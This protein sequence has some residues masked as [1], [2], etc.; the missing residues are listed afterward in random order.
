MASASSWSDPSSANVE[1][2]WEESEDVEHTEN[3]RF[4]HEVSEHTGM[5]E[6]TAF[7]I[8]MGQYEIRRGFYMHFAASMGGV[9][10]A[11]MIA[12]LLLA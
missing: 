9:F 7:R 12:K 3:S 1:V 2:T 8:E 4:V 5:S 6:M 11:L 10:L